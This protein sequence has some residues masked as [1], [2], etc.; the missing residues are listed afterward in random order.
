MDWKAYLTVFLLGTT[1]FMAAPFTGINGF[2][3][4]F[5]ETV[6]LVSLGGVIGTTIFYFLANT[7]LSSSKKKRIVKIEKLKAQG[8]SL[9]KVMTKTNKIIVKTKNMFGVWGLAFLTASILSI[10]I[11]SIICAK[12]YGHKKSTLFTIYV[13]IIINSLIMCSIATLFPT[14]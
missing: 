9:P 10:P 14:T 12:F 4:S 6:V 3:L 2:S 13:L 1:K 8:K 11:G 5:I 7:L